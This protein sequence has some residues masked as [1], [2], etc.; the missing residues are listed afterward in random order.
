MGE[1]NAAPAERNLELW[2][3]QSGHLI[4]GER[5]G[6]LGSKINT[7]QDRQLCWPREDAANW[8]LEAER[9]AVGWPLE[10][11]GS[12]RTSWEEEEEEEEEEETGEV[13]PCVPLI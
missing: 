7:M 1:L 11:G 2:G 8:R 12:R 6:Q 3:R 5:R 13:S 10:V 9:A 4:C